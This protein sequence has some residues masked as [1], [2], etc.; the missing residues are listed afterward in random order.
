MTRLFIPILGI[1]STYLLVACTHTPPPDNHIVT[2]IVN[3]K[4]APEQ[5]REIDPVSRVIGEAH[6]FHVKKMRST[7]IDNLLK[8]QVEVLN[9]RGRTD[10]LYYRVR[11]LDQTGMMQGQ[12]DTWQ[13]ES[14]EGGQSSIINFEAPADKVT[15]FRFEIKP[16]Y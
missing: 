9:D 5:A 15:D 2:Q 14:F 1:F 12:Y 6:S 11:W 16:Q 4:T 13:T 8:V 7:T 3:L 10:I